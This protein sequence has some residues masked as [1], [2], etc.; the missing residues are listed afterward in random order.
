M[1]LLVPKF[2]ATQSYSAMDVRGLTMD[3][4]IQ[5]GVHDDGDLQ[6]TQFF[7]GAPNMSVDVWG[8]TCFVRGTSTARQGL[9][10]VVNDGTRTNVAIGANS[11]GN[12]RLDQ[13]VA[14]VYDAVDGSSTFNNAF[15][16]VIQGTPSVGATLLNRT[17][18]AALPPHSLLLADVLVSNGALSIV[19][20]D[21]QDR[22]SFAHGFYFRG[23][24][25]ANAAGTS[26]YTTTSTT[27]VQI[28]ST[29]WFRQYEKGDLGSV[30]R[31]TL[32]GTLQNN[33]AGASTTLGFMVGNP[34]ATWGEGQPWSWNTPSV[35]YVTPLGL[36]YDLVVGA[37]RNWV[38]PC[39]K[40][41]GGTTTLY[42][43]SS[44]PSMFTIEEILKP[45]TLAETT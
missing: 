9:Y 1:T 39:W 15:L 28:D 43:S 37:G 13:V 38:S 5:A 2:L 23:V 31:V 42:A 36:V 25:N 10:H 24:R 3:M 19:N 22:R 12:P 16:E 11:S 33:S 14:R 32:S 40:T 6:V 27:S 35:S 18:A 20:T 34:L 41:T 17:G 29:N 4:G 7:D 26:N 44:T 8:G 45:G 30:I 21:I